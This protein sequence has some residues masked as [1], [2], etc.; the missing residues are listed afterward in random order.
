MR[1]PPPGEPRNRTAELSTTEGHPNWHELKD[2]GE[3]PY[4]RKCIRQFLEAFLPGSV[5]HLD[6]DWFE[7]EIL[8]G[9]K[10]GY[11]LT[12]WALLM[13]VG[14]V[15][16][17]PIWADPNQRRTGSFCLLHKG[18]CKHCLLYH[19]AGGAHCAT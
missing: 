7:K 1:G 19:L 15:D 3:T 14:K 5:Q 8:P 4:W 18:Q 9:F 13:C 16:T 6:F 10:K 2:D 11:A 12:W 17:K